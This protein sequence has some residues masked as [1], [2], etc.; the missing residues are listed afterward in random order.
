MFQTLK[1]I[2]NH[3][4][5]SRNRLAAYRR[6]FAWQI[7]TRVLGKTVIVPFVD[8][9]V[10]AVD[11]GMTGATGNVFCGLHEFED[12]AFVLHFAGQDDCF[13]DLGANVGSY[14]V[15][16]S[17]AAGAS[18]VCVEPLEHTY[19]L[20]RRN[21]LVNNIESKVTSL[22]TACSDKKGECRCTTDLDCMNHIVSDDYQG[23]TTVVPVTTIDDVLVNHKP[24]CW[25]VDVEG[26]EEA[27][28]RGASKSLASPVLQAIIMEGDTSAIRDVLTHAGF[29]PMSYDPFSRILSSEG[30]LRRGQN[31]LWI[32]DKGVVERKCQSSRSFT[33]VGLEI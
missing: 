27:V 1:Y 16:A 20:L 8:N 14:T 6:Y 11:C 13:F 3:P 5:S 33:V 23:P 18:T 30:T 25:K 12:M 9:A 4:V 32:R 22:Q 17:A 7:G 24:S 15:L 28:L 31:H 10:L 19:G 29:H 26:H 2:W 21:I